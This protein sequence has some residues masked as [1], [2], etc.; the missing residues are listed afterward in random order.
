M[1]PSVPENDNPQ[2][3][4]PLGK[5]KA[6][7]EPDGVEITPPTK[8]PLQAA[9][10]DDLDDELQYIGRTGKNA[11]QDFPHA[12]ENCAVKSFE[13]ANEDKCYE[14][15]PNCHC[16][17]CD[18]PVAACAEWDEHCMAQ[19]GL[20]RWQTARAAAK[21]RGAADAAQQQQT[22]STS[23]AS[24]QRAMLLGPDELLSAVES[25]H[26]V[27][28]PEPAGLRADVRLRPYQKQ[29]LAFALELE[30]SDDLTLVGREGSVRCAACEP[31][32]WRGLSPH[33]RLLHSLPGARRLYLRRDGH[34]QDCRVHRPRPRTA[35]LHALR[36]LRLL[37]RHRR[38]RAGVSAP[39]AAGQAR[40][41]GLGF[42]GGPAAHQARGIGLEIGIGAG[43]CA[44]APQTEGPSAE[45]DARRGAQHAH[46]AVVRGHAE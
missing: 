14:S 4:T 42:G 26:P 41:L 6:D 39:A 5:R 33:A 8:V 7:A 18:T 27:E 40:G 20:Q 44:D 23:A 12:R 9:G 10:A 38:G 13:P 2:G 36:L 31:P 17:V 43:F 25:V 29:S 16:Y 45:D 32:S 19:H 30:R 3:S 22:A 28:T 34:G 15:C 21:S 37:R 35:L 1:N 46:R 11:L 24:R